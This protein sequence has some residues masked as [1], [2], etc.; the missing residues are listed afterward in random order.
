MFMGKFVYLFLCEQSALVN[1]VSCIVIQNLQWRVYGSL[2][3]DI[4]E[5]C[6]YMLF[7]S[8]H[9][10]VA[11]DNILETSFYLT[12]FINVQRITCQRLFSCFSIW[13]LCLQSC[14][15]E[16]FNCFSYIIWRSCHKIS[17]NLGQTFE[18]IKGTLKK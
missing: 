9:G 15:W 3:Y 16:M 17:K 18:D 8:W 1:Y 13:T 12:C 6:I 11:L 10:L 14:F 5:N 2:K 4:V 7:T